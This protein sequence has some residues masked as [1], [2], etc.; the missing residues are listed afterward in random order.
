MPEQITSQPDPSRIM[1]IGL[2]FWASKVLLTAVKFRLFT[3]LAAGALS[4]REIKRKLAFQTTDR[5]VYDWLDALVSLGFLK[6]SGILENALYSNEAATDLFLDAGKQGYTG[7][8][9]E[10]ANSRLYKFWGDLDSGL[11]TGEPQNEIKHGGNMEFF[12]EL[13]KDPIKLQEFVSAMSGIQMA[14]FVTLVRQFDFSKYNSLI[15]LGGADGWLSIQI[16]LNH[17]NIRCKTFD[18]PPIESLA[19]KKIAEYNLSDRIE[20]VSGNFLQDEWPAAELITM[21]NILHGLNENNKQ[22]IINKVYEELPANG[23]FIVIENIIDNERR[24]NTFGLLMS[25]NMLIENGEA[26]DYTFNDFQKWT[27]VAGFKR[28]EILPLAGPTSAAIA[29]KQ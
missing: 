13:Y 7:G 23:A 29:Y 16:C 15:D 10:M 26:F 25:L 20:V 2:G 21:G 6:R 24:S 3:L 8:I 4:A 1:Q 27:T 5:H 11:E 19:K 9:L 22:D 14:N 28:T 12:E 18:L 17:S